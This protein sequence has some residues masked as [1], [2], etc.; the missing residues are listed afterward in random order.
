MGTDKHVLWQVGNLE[1]LSPQGAAGTAPVE[2]KGS[3]HTHQQLVNRAQVPEE[4]APAP[5]T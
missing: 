1:T 3:G 5:R 2:A 4:R